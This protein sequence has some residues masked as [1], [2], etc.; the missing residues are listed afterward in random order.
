LRFLFKQGNVSKGPIPVHGRLNGRRFKQ[1]VVKYQ[2]A[3]RLYL[4]TQL[5]LS[6][7]INTGDMAHFKIEFDSQPRLVGMHP[8]LRRTFNA[9]PAAKKSFQK[10][11]PSRQKEILRYLHSLKTKEAAMRTVQKVL[12]LLRRGNRKG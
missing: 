9:N 4:N 7:G 11:P 12:S 8:L 3:W 10:L 5:R 1:T 2:G 6:A